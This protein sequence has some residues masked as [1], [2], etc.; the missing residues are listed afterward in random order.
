MSAKTIYEIFHNEIKENSL[1]ALAGNPHGVHIA[2][3][4]LDLQCA[5]E[6]FFLSKKKELEESA[7]AHKEMMNKYYK[8]EGYAEWEEYDKEQY[9]DWSEGYNICLA[10]IKLL[11]KLWGEELK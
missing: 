10:E 8:E 1:D 7:I 3:D 4:M 2:S 5:I 6:K 11:D 9:N